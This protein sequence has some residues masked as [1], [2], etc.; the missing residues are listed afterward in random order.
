[1]SK[2]VTNSAQGEAVYKIKQAFGIAPTMTIGMLNSF[3]A[4]KIA[5]N[6]RAYVLETMVKDGAIV[7]ERRV[8]RSYK[9]STS[10]VTVMHWNANSIGT[11]LQV[12]KVK[13][14]SLSAESEVS[15][16]SKECIK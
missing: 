2:V 8:I 13:E 1:M 10:Y 14:T 15:A 7:I 12:K 16:V 9:G 6:V 4:G 3:T 5:P 11:S